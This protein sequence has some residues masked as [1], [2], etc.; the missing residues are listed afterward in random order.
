MGCFR[1][2]GI[3]E[4]TSIEKAQPLA[5]RSCAS[6]LLAPAVGL[7]SDDGVFN[8]LVGCTQAAAKVLQSSPLA[9]MS[10]DD[11]TQVDAVGDHSQGTSMHDPRV[12]SAYLNSALA[13]VIAGWSNLTE[14]EQAQILTIVTR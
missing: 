3:P 12:P 11:E 5:K 14:S 7:E 6:Q 4:R 1:G 9:M 10:P 8:I 13:H 2:G